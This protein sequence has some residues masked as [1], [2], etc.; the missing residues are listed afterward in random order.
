MPYNGWAVLG[1]HSSTCNAVNYCVDAV[2]GDRRDG[3]FPVMA[4]VRDQVDHARSAACRR[5]TLRRLR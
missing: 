4:T 5:R 2:F 1:A 3:T